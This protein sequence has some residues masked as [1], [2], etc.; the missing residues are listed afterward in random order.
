MCKD[1]AS[2][3]IDSVARNAGVS[4]ESVRRDIQIAIEEAM[5]NCDPAV[6]TRWRALFPDGRV[7]TPEELIEAVADAYYASK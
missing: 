5:R 4:P 3:A 6:R 7:P 2:R 1:R